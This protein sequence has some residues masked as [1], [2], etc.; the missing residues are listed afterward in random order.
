MILNSCN[1]IILQR[2]KNFIPKKEM[3]ALDQEG[4]QLVCQ[5]STKD[6]KSIFCFRKAKGL[7]INSHV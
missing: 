4:W 7:I 3:K 6:A 1:F 2:N 5:L